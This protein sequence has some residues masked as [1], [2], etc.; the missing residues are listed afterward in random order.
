[1]QHL[2]EICTADVDALFAIEQLS[3]EYPWTRQQ[4]AD[5]LLA[6]GSP[7]SEFGWCIEVDGGIAGFAVFNSVLDEATLLNTAVAP[8]YRRRGIARE[9]L[10]HALRELPSRG[11]VRC[12]LEVRVSNTSA[13]AIYE[14]LGFIADGNRRNYYPAHKTS[15]T[16]NGREDALLMSRLLTIPC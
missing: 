3:T 14:Q 4:F 1:M 2:R 5:G 6:G 10:A 15:S 9:L 12:L 16:H 8:A 11:I 13:I 7:S